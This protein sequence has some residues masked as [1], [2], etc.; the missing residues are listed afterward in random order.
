[1]LRTAARRTA[2]SLSS[3]RS[4]VPPWL[5]HPFR[6]Q[7]AP[8]PWAAVLRGALA[9]GPLLALAVVTGH[10]GAGVMAGMGAML[11]GVNDRPGT[12]RTGIA[13]IGL[14]ALMGAVGLLSGSLLESVVPSAWWTLPLL[15][16]VAM[17]GGTVSIS[18]QVWSSAGMQLIVTTT[19]GA[20]MP[21][22]GN[23]G[24]KALCFLAGA[25]WLLLLRLV[26]RTPRQLGGALGG[27]L[28]GERA[29]VAGVFDALADALEA[30]GGPRAETAR[31]A[32]TGALDRAD[33]ALRLH[34]LFRLRRGTPAEVLLAQQFASATALCESSVALL[35]EG[36][37]LPERV[38]AGP[39]RLAD[40]V[41]SG[42]R[43]GRLPS[44]AS[45]SP[46]RSSFDRALL[47]AA[48]AF[49]RTEPAGSAGDTDPHAPRTARGNRARY[50]RALFGA[51]GRSYGIRVA[52]CVTASAV[53]ALLLGTEHWFWLP[54]TAAFLVKPDMGPLFSRTVNRFAGTALGVLVFAGLA[55]LGQAVGGPWWPALLAGAAGSAVPVATRHFA[56]Q[57]SVITVMVLSFVW[58]GGDTQ[59]APDRL[60][61]TAIACAIVLLVGHL[62]QLVAPGAH[63]GN[64]FAV[65]LRRTEDYVRHVLTAPRGSEA[66]DE[67]RALRRA[68]YRALGEVRALAAKAAAEFPS[69]RGQTRDWLALLATA[70]RVVDAATACA[71]RLEHGGPRPS[72]REVEELAGQLAQAAS[73]MDG[74]NGRDRL[75]HSGVLD[76]VVHRLH[77]TGVLTRAA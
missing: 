75:A 44:P 6:W 20:G 2:D 35:W 37:A 15:F 43:P 11:A 63:V 70:E 50:R 71:V 61:H 25:G 57:T 45:D 68:A 59:A 51:A 74:R 58:T 49:S 47:K 56:L 7:R 65:G 24:F 67:R 10:A 53:V 17:I 27:A 46:A 72:V 64:R 16:A 5:V 55:T 54:A 41:R 23:P 73:D 77:H 29:A 40:A 52:V 12:R 28:H 9:A 31:R 69:R 33:E 36:R 13:H 42:E 34:R 1:M 14:P 4:S 21:M 32:L 19:V 18:G 26:L 38:I 22:P 8:V 3:A 62:P 76:S 48:V 39:R 66:D 30:A 60:T